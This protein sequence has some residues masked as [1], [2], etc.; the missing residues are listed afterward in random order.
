MHIL[1]VLRI[2]VQEFDDVL[3]L[4]HVFLLIVLE[5]DDNLFFEVLLDLFLR[6]VPDTIA[7]QQVVHNDCIIEDTFHTTI[8]VEKRLLISFPFNLLA[9]LL[10]RSLDRIEEVVLG[11]SIPQAPRS[12]QVELLRHAIQHRIRVTSERESFARVVVLV[13]IAVIHTGILIEL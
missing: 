8:N 12:S 13:I 2:F 11:A 5:S 3:N 6:T 1:A 7:A 4:S 10:E 9:W